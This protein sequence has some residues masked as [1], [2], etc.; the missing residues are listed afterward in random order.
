MKH[1]IVG[2]LAAILWL[3]PYNCFSE[4]P[5]PKQ[6]TEW[7]RDA[8]QGFAS[9]QFNLG[10]MHY[11]GQGVPTDYAEAIKWLRLAAQQGSASAQ[12]MLGL[13][14]YEG[15]GM[16]VRK[17][18][19]EAIKWFRLAARQGF[20]SAQFNLGVMYSKGQ[21]VP[22]DNAEAIKWLRLAAQRGSASAQNMLNT[23]Y[24]KEIKWL[25]LGVRSGVQAMP[26]NESIDSKLE[27]LPEGSAIVTAPSEVM[28]YKE[29]DVSLRLAKKE[30]AELMNYSKLPG[31]TV[32]GIASVRMSPR[33]KAEFVGGDF[34]IIGQG[35]QEQAVTLKNDTVWRW[36]AY[37]I[38]PG[39]RT[40]KVL[41]HTLVIIDGNETP[42]TLDVGEAIVTIKVN[43]AEFA[44]RNWQWIVSVIVLPII[45]WVVKQQ[46]DNKNNIK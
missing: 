6:I 40:F 5:S 33:M 46:L 9:A 13:I 35:I 10:V 45:A 37:S 42:K 12:N 26:H 25:L 28:Q 29:F 22:T 41:L 8:Q 27:K 43:P 16:R 11:K 21:G 30:L 18:Y 39:V 34:T 14:Y 4:A 17:D 36:R 38:R 3:S 15:Q 31:T 1:C 23:I 44:L 20:A 7:R 32:E 19:A 2:I 24:T